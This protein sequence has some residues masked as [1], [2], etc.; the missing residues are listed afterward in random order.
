VQQLAN[1]IECKQ[2]ILTTTENALSVLTVLVAVALLGWLLWFSRYGFDFTDEGFYLNWISRP[3]NYPVSTT[4][5]GFIYHPL[6][7]AVGGDVASLRQAN[8]LLLF[9]LGMASAWVHLGSIFGAQKLS[10]TSKLAVSAAMA[11][12]AL[13]VVV[14]GGMWLP[15][16]SYNSLT[17]QGLLIGV[18]GLILAEKELSRA[19]FFGWILIAFGGW[20]TF[21]AKPPSAALFALGCGIYLLMAGKIR[22]SSLVILLGATFSLLLLS[23]WV[24]DGS[25]PVFVERIRAGAELTQRQGG[26]HEIARIIRLEDLLLTKDAKQFLCFVTATV[27]SMVWLAQVQL[28]CLSIAGPVLAVA[29]GIIS[30]LVLFG[31]FPLQSILGQKSGL[32]IFAVSFGAAVAGLSIYR[33]KGLFQIIRGHWALLPLFLVLP[34]AYAFGTGGNYWIPITSAGIFFVFVAYLLLGP[35]VPLQA[36]PNVLLTVGLAVQAVSAILLVAGMASPYRQPQPLSQNDVVA[37]VGRPGA[38]LILARNHGEYISSTTNIARRAGFTHGSPIIDLTGKSPGLVYA[39]GANSIGLPWVIGGYPG[40]DRVTI[41]KLKA[42]PCQQ[43]A[44][45]WILSEPDGSRAI[46]PQVLTS[47]GGNINTDFERVG[48]LVSPEGKAQ[49]LL[50][51]ARAIGDAIAACEAARALFP[52][53]AS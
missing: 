22:F 5:F 35:M 40:S 36:V 2:R 33:L 6:Y 13:L 25:I 43:L 23:A 34:Y 28:A 32:V 8:I 47:F 44:S 16:P 4:Q 31:L 38:T 7:I 14:F 11:T 48:S 37:E 3:F 49:K 46:S 45:A 42:V 17:F 50:R 10:F 19:S 52:N 24:I 41:A 53:E 26:G 1:P 18:T 12:P 20:I 15:T 39:L 29:L 21:M 27:F 51:P 9:C 30:F